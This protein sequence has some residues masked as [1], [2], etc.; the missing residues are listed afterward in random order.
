[1]FKSVDEFMTSLQFHIRLLLVMILL[2][3]VNH[4]YLVPKPQ[5]SNHCFLEDYLGSTANNIILQ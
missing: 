4:S 2:N 5:W 1:M 3:R